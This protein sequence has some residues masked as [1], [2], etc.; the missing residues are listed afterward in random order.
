MDEKTDVQKADTAPQPTYPG[1]MAGIVERLQALA[2]GVAPQAPRLPEQSLSSSQMFG[3]F[4]KGFTSRMGFRGTLSYYVLRQVAERSL[5]ISACVSTRKHQKVRFCQVAQRSNRGKV[6]YRVVHARQHEKDFVVP[7]GFQDLCRE[8]EAMLAKPWR[9]YWNDGVVFDEVEPTL[10][11]FMSKITE[12]EL[13]IN[14]PCVELGLDLNRVP[15]TFGAIDGANVIPTF[16][17]LKYLTSINRDMPK[18]FASTWTAYKQTLQMV[19]DKYKIDLDERTAWIYM[20]QG[21]PT[22]GFRQDELIVAPFLPV[23]NVFLAGYPKSM[24]EQAIWGVLAEIMAMTANSRYFEFGSMAETLIAI[25]GNYQDKHIKDIEQIFQGNLSGV[26]GMFRVPIIALAGGKDDIDVIKVKENHKD[27]LFDVYVQK[28]T[29]L[30]CAIFRMH[31]SEINEAPRAGDNSSTLQQASQK[32]QINMS[33]EQGLETSLEHDKIHIFDPIL[34][35]VDPNLRMEWEYGRQEA[36]QLLLAQGYATFAT[37]NEQ[38]SMMGMDPLDDDEQG[39]AIANPAIMQAKQAEAQQDM[40]KQQ[41]DIQK[42]QMKDQ[43]EA[44]QQQIAAGQQQSARD[45]EDDTSMAKRVAAKQ[46][47]G[48]RPGL[49]RVGGA[50]R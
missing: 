38:R 13:V 1:G 11:S 35:R 18:D 23:S 49:A 29:N 37:V 3:G 40:Q 31:P 10:A 41:L 28:L 34:H 15:R 19:G 14:R 48:T 44:G 42:Q 24:V 36:D 27:M 33:Q 46:G 9:V 17:A 43:K 32:Q 30:I 5:L 7:K 25:K 20:L 16:A 6:G 26:P 21:R 8:A 45:S 22:A 4:Q 39:N 12:D 50:A 2:L 47:K